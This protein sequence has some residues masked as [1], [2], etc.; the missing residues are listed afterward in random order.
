MVD[1]DPFVPYHYEIEMYTLQCLYW[2]PTENAFKT[3]GCQVPF[4]RQN[5]FRIN[6]LLDRGPWHCLTSPWST[7]EVKQLWSGSHIDGWNVVI[8]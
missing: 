1:V 2:D 5:I 3:D 8:H 4:V 7:T 6:Y